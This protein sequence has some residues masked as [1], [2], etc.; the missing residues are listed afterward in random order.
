MPA[1]P[2]LLFTLVPYCFHRV[3]TVDLFP[4]FVDLLWLLCRLS[5]CWRGLSDV[6]GFGGEDGG[7]GV[8][9]WTAF[10]LGR[11]VRGSSGGS[12]NDGGSWSRDKSRDRLIQL[13]CRCSSWD[14][15]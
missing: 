2:S 11:R 14:F 5:L 9:E 6:G 15:R 1:I 7:S 10:S 3:G 8:F 12:G 4:L 13:L